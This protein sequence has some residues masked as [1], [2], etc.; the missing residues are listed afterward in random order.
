MAETKAKFM[1][2]LEASEE[3]VIKKMEEEDRK[4]T[5]EDAKEQAS[6]DIRKGLKQVRE[7]NQAIRIMENDPNE[8]DIGDLADCKLQI[9]VEEEKIEEMKKLFKEFFG[10]DFK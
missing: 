3:E 10:E 7:I 6:K 5:F 9:K 8:F 1:S 2:M 4:D